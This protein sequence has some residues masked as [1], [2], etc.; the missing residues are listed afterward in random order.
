MKFTFFHFNK[1]IKTCSLIL[2]VTSKVNN[3]IGSNFD[4]CRLK[5]CTSWEIYENV[6]CGA[7]YELSYGLVELPSTLDS[8]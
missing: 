2:S 3:E 6:I 4:S 1:K 7:I 8:R 5:D